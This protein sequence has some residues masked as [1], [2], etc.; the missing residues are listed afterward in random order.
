[1][2]GDFMG[3]GGQ[4]FPFDN[5]GDT[6]TGVILGPNPYEKRVQTKTD[7]SG[8]PKT[9]PDGSPMT[10]FQVRLQTQVRDPS[11]PFD[12]GVRSVFLKWKSQAAVQLAVRAAGAQDLA[13]GG[14]LTLQFVGEEPPSKRGQQPVKLWRAHYVPPPPG[15]MAEQAPGSAPGQWGGQQNQPQQQ[16]PQQQPPAAGVPLIPAQQQWPQYQSEFT[17]APAPQQPQWPNAAPQYGPPQTVPGTPPPVMSGPPPAAMNHHGQPQAP[18]PPDW[19]QPAPQQ[20]PPAQPFPDPWAGVQATP[21]PPPAPVSAQPVLDAGQQS[22][23]DRLRQQ[24]MAQGGQLPPPPPQQQQEIP[25]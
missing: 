9:F 2:S 22:V 23:I 18:Q 11:N 12:D 8:E 20:Q 16:W 5:V 1:M 19:A 4:S 13:V 25:Y 24:A 3:G 15:F 6:V 17:Y 10:M 7:G 14:T 21:A